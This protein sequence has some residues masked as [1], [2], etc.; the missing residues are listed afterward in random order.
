MCASSRCAAGWGHAR[1]GGHGGALCGRQ[2]RTA[3]ARLAS[4]SAS[5]SR[6]HS[7]SQPLT[8]R[9]LRRDRS[10]A[11]ATP[12][13]GCRR[14]PRQSPLPHARTPH[15]P[16]APR[17]GARPGRRCWAACLR[18]CSARGHSRHTHTCSVCPLL[19]ARTG[20][21]AHHRRPE[22]PA[23]S[24]AR[25]GGGGHLA[26]LRLRHPPNTKPASSPHKSLRPPRLLHPDCPDSAGQC[27]RRA[28]WRADDCDALMRGRAVRGSGR[29]AGEPAPAGLPPQAGLRAPVQRDRALARGERREDERQPRAGGALHEEGAL[30]AAATV[31]AAEAEAAAPCAPA[32]RRPPHR[33]R[34]RA[35]TLPP[36]RAHLTQSAPPRPSI[37]A[38]ISVL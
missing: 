13:A 14:E 7:V 30:L 10:G 29:L 38:C 27:G 22:P 5:V 25:P 28:L 1:G 9:S 12:M 34:A 3:R 35:A 17:R 36:S 15:A 19:S 26:S 21:R 2:L 32:A 23:V 33:A 4:T 16:R 18:H 31:R 20:T 6:M 11:L 24:R 8:Q 37:R